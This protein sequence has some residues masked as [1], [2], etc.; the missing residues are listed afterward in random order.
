MTIMLQDF[1]SY[2]RQN[3]YQVKINSSLFRF[4]ELFYVAA[5][6]YLLLGFLIL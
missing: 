6:R 5:Q 2:T 4:M 1:S 3:N